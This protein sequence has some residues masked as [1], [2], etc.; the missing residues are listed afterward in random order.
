M[1][2]DNL[3]FIGAILSIA[4]GGLSLRLVRRNQTLAWNEAI[5][6]HILCL[7]F[8][9]KGIQNA[10]TG[11]FNQA[12]GMEWQFWV[13]LS[14]SMDYIFSS[15]VL[16]IALLYP[17]PFLRNMKQV[18][19]GLGLVGGFAIYRLTLDVMGLNFTALGL[20]GVIY[21]A[22]AIL[23]GSVYFRFRLISPEKRNDSTKNISL[24][25]GLFATLVLGHIWMWWPGLILQSEY[26][27][28][29]D[30]GGGDFTSTLWDYMWMSGYSIG[31]AAGL[32]MICTEIYQAINGDFSKLLFIL[33]PYFVLG[34]IGF[35]IYTAYDDAGFVFNDS[36]DLLQIWSIF[37]TQLH[38]T[39]AR[40][41]IAMYIL[42][43]FGLFD[44]NNETKPMAKMMSIILI[45]VATSAIL[46]LVQAVIPIN[47]MIS[48]ALLGVIIAFGIGWEEKSFQN[49]VSNQA[50]LRNYVDK[51][52][53]P[54]ISIPRK[55]INKIDLACLVYCII[56]LLVAFVIWEMDILLQIA[57]ERGA[58]NDI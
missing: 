9:T 20:P 37:T 32:A 12:T 27:F 39:I 29:F 15:S 47:E 5:A 42:L 21:Y 23:W 31:I 11:Y 34:V 26:F 13:E 24:L 56:S 48:A 17:V 1:E 3:L 22:A 52:W 25:A 54:E 58:Q 8:I 55:Y 53:F 4:L 7:M 41:I 40:P 35:S 6:A 28:Y 43:K 18:K 2:E 10:A 46:E 57:L 44:I 30:L 33:L 16:A 50:H 51:K 14:F 36:T 45:V 19:I 49:L 38:F